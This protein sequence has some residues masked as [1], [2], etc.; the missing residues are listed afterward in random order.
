MQRV[1]LLSTSE[2]YE[3]YKNF[4]VK[5][6]GASCD[7]D[8]AGDSGHRKEKGPINSAIDRRQSTIVPIPGKSDKEHREEKKSEHNR[9]GDGGLGFH[10]GSIAGFTT[11]PRFKARSAVTLTE[12]ISKT[13]PCIGVSNPVST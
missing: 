12:G 6:K 13:F 5:V 4:S 9:T 8:F 1:H 7:L 2:V 11:L 3:S 10:A